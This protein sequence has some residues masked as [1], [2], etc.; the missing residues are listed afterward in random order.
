MLKADST[1]IG[2][3]GFGLIRMVLCS[4]ELDRLGPLMLQVSRLG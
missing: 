3:F 2:V 4:G 1:D